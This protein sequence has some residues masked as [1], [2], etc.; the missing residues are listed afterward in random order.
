L[1]AS[2]GPRLP[3]CWAVHWPGRI[4]AEDFV[5][6]AAGG[7]MVPAAEF[8]DQDNADASTTS[9]AIIGAFAIFVVKT[10]PRFAAAHW[11]GSLPVGQETRLDA[12]S[13]QNFP[14]AMASALNRIADH[15][16]CTNCLA[17]SIARA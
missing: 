12:Q 5:D 8:T 4:G 11:A 7:G 9:I 17:L 2:R 13:W 3:A 10:K 16:D 14:P 1:R 6:L 15:G